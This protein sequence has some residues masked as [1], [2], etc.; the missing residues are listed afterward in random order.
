METIPSN[1]ALGKLR[2][3]VALMKDLG[4][5]WAITVL[6]LLLATGVV[7]SPLYSRMDTFTR[8]AKILQSH[9]DQGREIVPL[10]R[11]ICRSV[12]KT[13]GSRIGCEQSFN[14]TGE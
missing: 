6:V 8:Q 12:A 2:E 1:G 5:P 4:M 7:P 9:I 3:Y 11:M 14:R 10:L 13:E